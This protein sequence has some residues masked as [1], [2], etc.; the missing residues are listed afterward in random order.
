MSLN[1]ELLRIFKEP[2]SDA[3]HK[4][5]LPVGGNTRLAVLLRVG[6]AIKATFATSW[7]RK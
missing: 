7:V 3:K 2:R 5:E 6:P 4:A 1:W